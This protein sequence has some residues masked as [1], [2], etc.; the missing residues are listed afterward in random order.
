VGLVRDLVLLLLV[1][2]RH[3]QNV[4]SIRGR[5]S[6]LDGHEYYYGPTCESRL[7]RVPPA[8]RVCLSPFAEGGWGWL[9]LF[10]S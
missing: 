9:M 2:L 3:T 4:G 10:S 8:F 7:A 1:A 5:D 6:A